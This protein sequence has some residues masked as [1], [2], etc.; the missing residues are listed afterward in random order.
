MTLICSAS[1]DNEE[2]RSRYLVPRRRA[3]RGECRSQASQSSYSHRDSEGA[4]ELAVEPAVQEVLQEASPVEAQEDTDETPPSPYPY[5]SPEPL[6]QPQ[7]QRHE[8]YME[9]S[10]PSS[11]E[12]ESG[13]TIPAPGFSSTEPVYA[14]VPPGERPHSE[15]APPS[16]LS[17]FSGLGITINRAPSSSVVYVY[18][19]PRP[20]PYRFSIWMPFSTRFMPH[21][22][23]P[24]FADVRSDDMSEV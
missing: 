15:P 7:P 24:G 22:T 6:Q 1:G 2:R 12:P 10:S 5:I 21:H 13:S 18:E 20:Q 19:S 4:A 3:R 17:E 8:Q 14:S 9:E 11:L 23:Q 16:P